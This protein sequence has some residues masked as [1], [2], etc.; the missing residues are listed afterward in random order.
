MEWSSGRRMVSSDPRTSTD[1]LATDVIKQCKSL[2]MFVSITYF[3]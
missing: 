2:D 3:Y 1:R